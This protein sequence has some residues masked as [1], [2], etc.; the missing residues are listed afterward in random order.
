MGETAVRSRFEQVAAGRGL[1]L[2]RHGDT[3]DSHETAVAWTFYQE[4]RADEATP[5]AGV[6]PHCDNGVPLMGGVHYDDLGTMACRREK[7]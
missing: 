5:E 6:C 2:D 1:R 4:G 7:D 3:Y